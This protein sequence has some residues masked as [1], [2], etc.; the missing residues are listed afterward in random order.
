MI[1]KIVS[2][3]KQSEEPFG[4][5]W[6]ANLEEGMKIWIQASEDQANPNWKRLGDL[7]EQAYMK[8]PDSQDIMIEA[9]LFGLK[10]QGA[11]KD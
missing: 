2:P 11:P 7:Y 1:E 9:L 10:Y 4:T 3:S 8:A 6:A 5:V